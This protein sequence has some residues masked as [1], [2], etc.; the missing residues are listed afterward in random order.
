MQSIFPPNPELRL[1][2]MD[3]IPI[4]HRCLLRLGSYPYQNDPEEFLTHDVL[5]TAVILVYHASEEIRSAYLDAGTR[6]V[7]LYQSMARL[8]R[9]KT[10]KRKRSADDDKDL[11]KV[12]DLLANRR[13]H[14]DSPK[15]MIR[16]P[17]HPPASHFPS[18][19]S[20]DFEQAIPVRDFRSFLRLMLVLNPCCSEIDV[21]NFAMTLTEVERVTDCIL[22]AFLRPGASVDDDITFDIFN[23]VIRENTVSAYIIQLYYNANPTK[24]SQVYSWAGLDYWN[25]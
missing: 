21:G 15:A 23:P 20:T 16:G 14:P 24:N 6:A 25:H 11:K 5:R 1:V 17:N 4:M 2:L 10:Q 18:S 8:D 7:V 9:G 22:S 3:A 13:R 12:L 19:W